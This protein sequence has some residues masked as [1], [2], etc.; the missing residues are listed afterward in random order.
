MQISTVCCIHGMTSLK[1]APLRGTTV[2]D[3]SNSDGLECQTSPEATWSTFVHHSHEIVHPTDFLCN[4]V[5]YRWLL[6]YR[7]LPPSWEEVA[8]SFPHGSN[9]QGRA[10][11]L[12]PTIQGLDTSCLRGGSIPQYATFS[13]AMQPAPSRLAPIDSDS[14]NGC[15]YECFA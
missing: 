1:Q 7:L 15:K 3:N 11:P 8:I 9:L 6:V 12:E 5:P 4:S 10:V 13:L 2:G 14:R